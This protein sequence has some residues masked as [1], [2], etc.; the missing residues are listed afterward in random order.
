MRVD[1]VGLCDGKVF[2]TS[3][4]KMAGVH[5]V[6]SNSKTYAPIVFTLGSGT[7]LDGF[8]EAVEGME[9]GEEKAV[10][11]PP[12]MA[13]GFHD[14]SKVKTFPKSFFEKQGIDVAPGTTMVFRIPS[15]PLTGWVTEMDDDNVTLD[16]NH[17]MAGK[18][19]QFR[20]TL[21]DCRSE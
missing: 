16:M 21:R 13:Y 11:L 3:I 17:E 9:V 19:L 20:I 7:M 10:T 6:R 1:Y 5:D 14:K 15:G 18:T 4:E 2:D 8:E 12:H